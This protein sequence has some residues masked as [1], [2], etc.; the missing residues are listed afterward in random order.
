[1][2]SPII[3]LF[4]SLNFLAHSLSDAINA[5]MQLTNAV[6]V[7]RQIFAQNCVAFSEPTGKYDTIISI[8]VSY[9]LFLKDKKFLYKL[10]EKYNK[11]YEF[12]LNKWYFDEIYNFIFVKNFK[13][14]GLFFW[15]IG[16]IKIIDQ[17]GPDGFA[18][19]IKYFSNK[20]V[21]FQSGYIY[22]YAL[23]MLV[24]FSILLTYLILI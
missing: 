21:L 17:F 20:A 5:G 9:H 14:A 16:D 10:V 18:K 13:K 24:G 23:V 19:L 8:P 12:L 7:S 22:H 2:S 1:M 3:G 6:F 4:L 15:K 11:I